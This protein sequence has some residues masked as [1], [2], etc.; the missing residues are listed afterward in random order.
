MN[1]IANTSEIS[2][3]PATFHDN[4]S[5]VA[6]NTVAKKKNRTGLTIIGASAL[7]HSRPFADAPS[8]PVDRR[9][10]SST[11]DGHAAGEFT[12]GWFPY[13]PQVAGQSTCSL[14]VC[15]AFSAQPFVSGS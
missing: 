15:S 14:S 9:R 5:N 6:Q 3:L 4:F 12:G 11:F 2:I 8:Q 13:P 1:P 10:S 7:A